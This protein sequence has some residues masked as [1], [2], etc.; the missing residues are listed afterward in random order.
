LPLGKN[1]FEI[2]HVKE[3]RLVLATKRE[4]GKGMKWEFGISGYKPV[5]KEHIDSKVLLHSTGNYSQYPV[6]KAHWKRR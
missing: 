1:I 2:S 3:N 5:Y 4:G 6:I